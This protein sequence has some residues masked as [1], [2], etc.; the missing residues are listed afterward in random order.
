LNLPYREEYIFNNDL[1]VEEEVKGK[2]KDK[3]KPNMEEMN[4]DTNN[5]D[6]DIMADEISKFNKGFKSKENALGFNPEYFG[7]KEKKQ[8]NMNSQFFPGEVDM[9]KPQTNNDDDISP[10]KLAKMKKFYQVGFKGLDTNENTKKEM[11]ISK[12]K[13]RVLIKKQENLGKIVEID[14]DDALDIDIANKNFFNNDND[15]DF[16]ED[17]KEKETTLKR[18]NK[19]NKFQDNMDKYKEFVSSTEHLNSESQLKSSKRETKQKN[20]L[21]PIPLKKKEGKK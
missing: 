11:Q 1:Q 4:L 20:F 15:E 9:R 5:V 16:E 21:G 12:D 7:I 13:K 8:L 10:E 2:L 19:K 3:R 14:E 6:V 17:E 18:R